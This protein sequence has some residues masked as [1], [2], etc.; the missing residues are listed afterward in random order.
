VLARTTARFAA[1]QRRTITL[2]GARLPKAVTVEVRFGAAN[3]V[4]RTVHL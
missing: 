1:G 4:R 3:A 2:S